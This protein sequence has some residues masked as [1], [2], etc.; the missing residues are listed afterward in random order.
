MVAVLV[1]VAMDASVVCGQR[2]DDDTAPAP[3]AVRVGVTPAGV[4]RFAPGGWSALTAVGSNATDQDHQETVSVWF[5]DD[6]TMQ[7]ATRFWIP[8]GSRRQTWLPVRVPED[9]DGDG[10][11]VELSMIRLTESGGQESFAENP[12]AMPVSNRSLM[13]SDREINTGVMGKPMALQPN[14]GLDIGSLHEVL[15]VLNAAREQ[16]ATSDLQLPP[17]HF[18]SLFLPPTRGSLDQLDQ[19]VIAGERLLGDTAGIATVRRWL[20]DGGRLWV[21]LDRTDGQLVTELLGTA[22]TITRVDTTEVNDVDLEIREPIKGWTQSTRQAWTSETPVTLLRVLT[23]ADD[24]PVRSGNWPLAFWKRIGKGEVL[25]TT[26]GA[27]G[28]MNEEGTATTSLQQLS[29]RFF[30]PREQPPEI[31]TEMFPMLDQRIGYRIPSRLLAGSILFANAIVLLVMGAVWTRQRKLER[32]A[33]LVPLCSLLSA[34][35][36]VWLGHRQTAAVPS[37]VAVGQWIRGVDAAGEAEVETAFA[38]YSQ[39]SETLSLAAEQTGPL[40]PQGDLPGGQTRRIVWDD[41]GESHWQGLR[42]P[43]GVVRH[44]TTKGTR[45]FQPPLRAPGTFDQTGFVG[46]LDGTD[47]SAAE[48]GVVIAGG[49]PA[50]AVR[51]DANGA[52]VAVRA[53]TSDRLTPQQYLP[54]GLISDRQRQR[55]EFLRSV[56]DNDPTQVFGREPTLLFWS[57]PID[58]G[59]S[60]PD[61]FEQRG[62]AL[63][64]VPVQ[65]TRPE[66]GTRFSIPATFIQTA[67]F[68]GTRGVSPIF[69]TETGQWL[70]QL[71]N[72]AETDLIFQVPEALRSMTISSAT[73]S[74]KVSAPLRTMTFKTIV[75]GQPQTVFQQRNPTGVIEFEIDDPNTLEMHPDGGLLARIE[76]TESEAAV[77]QDRDTGSG[78]PETLG[79]APASDSTTWQIDYVNVSLDGTIR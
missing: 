12:N 73:V 32:M 16:F 75:G 67:A 30:Q 5:G 48:D 58:L 38:V 78:G 64:S 59:V 36:I 13:L 18:T 3:P 29:Q 24:V 17:I 37:T 55:Q 33:G 31:A 54:D 25:F 51:F 45:L 62:S 8:A 76:I 63:V 27:R 40:L 52:D 19:L 10:K 60:W 46:R 65:I 43:P 35:A 34:A 2:S 61:G 57:D 70:T 49:G 1:A 68:A 72:P 7:Y 22:V 41:D 79:R 47:A 14:G 28:W 50:T 9:S 66:P 6:P 77:R 15:D 69:N 11:R 23:D 39:S 71:N 21:M 42:Q 4:E 20:R 53:A 56:A 44:M 74:I 26:L